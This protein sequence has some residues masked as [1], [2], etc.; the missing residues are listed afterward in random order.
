MYP[1]MSP[2]ERK[3]VQQDFVGMVRVEGSTVTIKYRTP[4]IPAQPINP[5]PVYKTDRR[6]QLDDE[7]STTAK[8]LIRIVHAKDLKILGFGLVQVGDAILYFLDTLNLEEPLT[9]KPVVVGTL[10]FIDP[11]G[12]QWVPVIDSGPLKH[13]LA[14][15]LADDA[16]SQVVPC[17]L[18]K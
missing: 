8:C 5:D 9:N 3:L 11:H 4:L 2:Y 10:Y 1:F 12:N 6:V 14:M 18:R 17:T 7:Q 15:V 13:Y 16:I